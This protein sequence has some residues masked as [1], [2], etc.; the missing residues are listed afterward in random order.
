MKSSEVPQAN[1]LDR[2]RVFVEAVRQ[3]STQK[4][5]LQAVTGLSARHADYYGQAARL[6]GYLDRDGETYRLLAAGT[7]LV[8]TR[9]GSKEEREAFRAGIE[10]SD[11][12]REVAPDLLADPGPDEDTLT[13]RIVQATDLAHKTARRRAQAVLMWRVRALADTSESTDDDE[14][15]PLLIDEDG[16]AEA[17]EAAG[18]MLFARVDGLGIRHFKGIRSA[19]F[20]LGGLTVF[21][22]THGAGK[23]SLRDVF[24]FLHAVGRGYTLSEIAGERW[25]EG[26]TLEWTGIRGGPRE[27]PLLGHDTFALEAQ[28]AVPDGNQLR[29]ARFT[30]EVR[31]SD[32]A[33]P[34]VVRERLEVDGRGL[35]VYDSHPETDPPMQMP[36]RLAVRVGRSSR[37]SGRGPTLLVDPRKPALSQIAFHPAVRTKSVM[38]AAALVVS[39]FRSLR[40]L[41]LDPVAMRRPSFPG[42]LRLGDRGEN[43]SSVLHTVS[44]HPETRGIL[45]HGLKTFTNGAAHDVAFTPDAAGRLLLSLE[46][47]SGRA[48]SAHSVSNGTLHFLGLM[49]ALLGPDSPGFWFFDDVDAGLC[50]TS[51]PIV[52][53]LLERHATATTRQVVVTTREP[54]TLE[55]LDLDPEAITTAYRLHRGAAPSVERICAPAKLNE[56]PPSEEDDDAPPF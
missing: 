18:P 55:A 9:P 54:R 26:G 23:T 17:P 10:Q 3:G 25:G 24:R 28:V 8:D 31:I 7:A 4:K 15:V 42:Q 21:V 1:S 56:P 19:S 5:Q 32:G 44:K 14:V 40:F 48:L 6:L 38:D 20:E 33:A 50:P 27:L 34:R 16:E 11:I 45:L 37:T 30:I 41:E 12:V 22:G 47:P 35:F 46:D 52:F 53:E 43:L 39:A 29:A 2:V 49:A 13:E 51:L 36:D